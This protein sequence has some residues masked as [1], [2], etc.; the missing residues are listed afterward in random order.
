MRLGEHD[1]NTEPDCRTLKGNLTC[2][3]NVTDV[4]AEQVF[5]H[6]K[7]NSITFQYDIALIKLSRD[8]YSTGKFNCKILLKHPK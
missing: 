6:E 8:V 4:T 5:I 3:P 2:A 1:K 7:F